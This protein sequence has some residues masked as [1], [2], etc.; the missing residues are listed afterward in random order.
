MGG[1]E[2][3]WYVA[4]IEI[5]DYLKVCRDLQ[6]AA[7]CSFVYNPGAASAWIYVEDVLFTPGRGVEVKGRQP[8][9]VGVEVWD[10]RC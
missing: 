4:N 5:I 10:G 6:F 2:D 9:P 3:I 8:D 7:D 1:R